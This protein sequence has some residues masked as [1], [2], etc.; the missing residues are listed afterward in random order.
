MDKIEDLKLLDQIEVDV[1]GQT[2]RLV[3]TVL[4]IKKDKTNATIGFDRLP[5]LFGT[6]IIQFS[7]HPDFDCA[8]ESEQQKFVGKMGFILFSHHP[9]KIVKQKRDYS[10]GLKCKSCR[11][12]FPFAVPNQP[13]GETLVCWG[14]RNFH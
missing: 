2:G 8:T 5:L 4:A 9:F 7:A 3:G 14:C 1:G 13:D 12:D 6:R 10:A 11:E